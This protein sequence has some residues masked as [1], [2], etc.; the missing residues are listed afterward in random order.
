MSATGFT[1]IVVIVLFLG[2]IIFF[3]IVNPDRK[4]NNIR[5][6]PAYKKIEQEII[7][8]VEDGTQLHISLGRG[9]ITG[10]ESA[11]A[12]AG[13]S[14]LKQVIEKSSICDLPPV[15]STGNAVISM[16]AQDTIQGS[17]KAVSV[18]DHIRNP[19]GELI[20]VTPFSYAAGTLTTI[21]DDNVSANIHAGWFGN[22]ITWLTTAGERQSTPTIAG[23]AQLPAQAVIYASASD[24]LIGE[25]LYAA[26]A[27]LGAGKIHLASI[28]AQDVVRWIIIVLILGNVLLNLLGI[29]SFIENILAGSM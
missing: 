25:E 3:S 29:D 18:S 2:L 10:P 17:S 12:L 7:A 14:L 21:R 6:I 20:G 19:S 8:A 5:P 11:A 1:G 27:Y 16:L 28:S 24:P 15:V 9:G 23:T 13:L 4:E 26:G 22:E